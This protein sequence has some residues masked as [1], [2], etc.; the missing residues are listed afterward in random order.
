[1][2]NQKIEWKESWRDE[3]LKWICGFANAQ[4]GVLEIGRNDK[5]EIVGLSDA[6]KLLEELP[7]KIR[8]TMGII[9]DVNIVRDLKQ[10]GKEYITISIPVQHNAISYRGRY[11]YRSG[12]TNQELTGFPL[13]E[14]LLGKYGK[15]W[16]SVPVPRIKASEFYHDTFDIFRKKAIASGR[17]AK[18]D[19]N[20]SDEELF[21][22]LKLTE[23]D[24]LL[25]AGVLLFHHEPENWCL[26]CY[27]KIGYFKTAADLIYQDEIG[28][29]ILTIPDKV[30]DLIYTK[31]FKGLIHYE[32]I[33][34]VDHYPMPRDA[35]RE[36]ILNAVV[37]RS[38]ET[39]NPIQIRVFD[40]KV[41]IYNSARFPVGITEKDLQN[42]HKSQPYNPLIANV[43]FRSGQI[44]AWGR[45]IEKIKAACVAVGLPEPEFDVT[46]DGF[47]VC[48]YTH[49]RVVL[50]ENDTVNGDNDTVNKGDDTVNDTV[51]VP[52]NEISVGVNEI[53]VPVNVPVNNISV[54]VNVGVNE[55]SV[56]VNEINIGVNV[57]VNEKQQKILDLMVENGAVTAQEI[58]DIVGITKRR[59]ES[60]IS[61][62]KKLGKIKRE[63]ADKNGK[64][65]VL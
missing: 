39:G 62:L 5:G 58:A 24:Y 17:L 12:S 29:P 64:W 61:D 54:G 65:V 13:D 4:G 37:H 6:K 22:A 45:G 15:T 40:D 55:I 35:L 41:C 27:V 33:Q 59:V 18:E 32:G 14:L 38:Y 52:V 3:H 50:E 2:E 19:V 23:G 9:A 36:A 8:T 47:R 48:F 31:Y 7:N 20:M 57:G 34:R 49:K 30:M 63:G 16:D 56:G 26:G 51:N 10:S 42:A 1:M 44:E 25:K 43:F 46:V 53:D 60:N 28:G 21:K 11:Y